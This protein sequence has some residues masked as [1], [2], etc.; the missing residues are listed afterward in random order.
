APLKEIIKKEYDLNNDFKFILAGGITPENVLLKIKEANPW[1]VDVSS[2][3][4]DINKD[5]V[6]MKSFDKMKDLI[7]K[8]R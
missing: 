3:V 8:I 1:G 7:N 4:E 2:G 5:G 6:T